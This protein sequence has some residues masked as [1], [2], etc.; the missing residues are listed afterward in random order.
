MSSFSRGHFMAHKS[1]SSLGVIQIHS[2][3]KNMSVVEVFFFLI[4]MI[5][6]EIIILLIVIN[7]QDKPSPPR[8]CEAFV[9]I[10]HTPQACTNIK[11]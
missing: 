6:T 11:T 8:K 2:I 1:K 9:Y 7:Q 5:L 4:C 10:P 3:M